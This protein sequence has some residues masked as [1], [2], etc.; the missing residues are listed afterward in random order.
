MPISCS[1]KLASLPISFERF[2]ITVLDR[3]EDRFRS[4]QRGNEGWRACAPSL[5]VP[6][7]F[8][9]TFAALASARLLGPVVVSW[10]TG[11]EWG[12]SPN[13]TLMLPWHCSVAEVAP[14]HH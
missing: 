13:L 14:R 5:S 6:D 11:G 1:A 7:F 2:L 12:P 10:G 4:M 8:R 3:W 9:S